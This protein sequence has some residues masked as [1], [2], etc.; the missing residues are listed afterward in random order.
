MK[1]IL[2]IIFFLSVGL[3][4]MA[5]SDYTN[6]QVQEQVH[7][8]DESQN[9]CYV[10]I[11]SVNYNLQS[12]TANVQLRVYKNKAKWTQNKGW[13]MVECNEVPTF[14]SVT[15]PQTLGVTTLTD[16]VAVQVKAKL[17]QLNPTWNNNSIDLDKPNK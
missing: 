5:Q 8:Q 16:Y 6:L 12:F 17:L 7:F 11:T 15:L 4:C 14:L 2:S 1:R 3:A 13:T 9:K 10:V